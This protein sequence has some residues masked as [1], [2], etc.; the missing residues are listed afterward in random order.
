MRLDKVSVWNAKEHISNKNFFLHSDS[1]Q[2]LLTIHLSI[3]SKCLVSTIYIGIASVPLS[4]NKMFQF[5][6]RKII[7]ITDIVELE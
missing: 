6:S 1:Y 4:I 3:T 7:S 5:K 2:I